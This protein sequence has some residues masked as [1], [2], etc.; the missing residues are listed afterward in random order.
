MIAT[1][2]DDEMISIGEMTNGFKESIERLKTKKV[3]K[4]AIMKNDKPEAILI[5]TDEYERLKSQIYWASLS[6]E[7]YLKKAHEEL[8]NPD[9]KSYTIEE[10]E[11]FLG[12]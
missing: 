5:S 4:I 7:E 6:E 10:A 12:I 8:Y 11:R 3:E 9:A 2:T 1:Y